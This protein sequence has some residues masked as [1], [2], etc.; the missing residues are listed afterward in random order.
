[1]PRQPARAAAL[2]AVLPFFA[3]AACSESSPSASSQPSADGAAW[4]L[5]AEPTGAR[6]VAEAK[7]SA[8]EGDRVVLRGRIGGRPQPVSGES[9]VFTVMDLALPYC[10]QE[11]DDGC[12]TPWD[13]CCETPEAITASSATVQVAGAA[14]GAIA[15]NLAPLDEVV[16]VGTV[17]PRPSES[18]LTI[19]AEGVHKT[20]R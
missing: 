14:D 17:G 13:Y 19:R 4:L 18:V 12:P 5:G 2:I 15:K 7:A 6:A 16:V 9:P 1:M 10:G 20:A 8:V 11:T 3:L